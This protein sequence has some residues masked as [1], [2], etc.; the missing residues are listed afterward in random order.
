MR[1]NIQLSKS[2]RE[3]LQNSLSALTF[4]Q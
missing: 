2:K 1:I 4:L 3:I